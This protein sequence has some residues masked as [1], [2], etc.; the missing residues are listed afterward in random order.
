LGHPDLGSE[1]SD[2]VY[3]DQASCEG[4]GEIWSI[5]HKS[6]SHYLVAGA[7]NNYSQYGGIVTG[8]R[9]FASMCTA[10]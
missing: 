6:G 3:A 9:N 4:A 5:S 2:D 10:R 7:Q 8:Y 1:Q